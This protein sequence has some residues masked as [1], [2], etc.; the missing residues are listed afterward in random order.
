MA[1]DTWSAWG[2]RKDGQDIIY[3]NIEDHNVSQL[4]TKFSEFIIQQYLHDKHTHLNN[5]AITNLSSEI[6]DVELLISKEHKKFLRKLMA[7]NQ[8]N[9][10][11]SSDVKYWGTF[12][13][14]E[15][16]NPNFLINH[17][18]YRVDFSNYLSLSD[19][20]CCAYIYNLD[21]QTLEIYFGFNEQLGDGRYAQNYHPFIISDF[22]GVKLVKEI[23]IENLVNTYQQLKNTDEWSLTIFQEDNQRTMF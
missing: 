23:P 4:G 19:L 10:P 1:F 12:F 3:V 20:T 22:Y 9:I 5:I 6:V 11:Q 15:S 14:Q 13:S 7:N 2:V 17:M 16:Y 21:T 18:K 8:L